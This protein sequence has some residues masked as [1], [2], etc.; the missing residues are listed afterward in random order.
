[1]AEF[2]QLITIPTFNIFLL[3]LLFALNGL[4]N[5]GS[6]RQTLKT[7]LSLCGNRPAIPF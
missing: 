7:R 6:S 3:F 1:M 2:K 4:F 5:F